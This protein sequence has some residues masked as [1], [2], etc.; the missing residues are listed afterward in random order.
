[1][2]SDYWFWIAFEDL[3]VS[4][5]F[6]LSFPQKVERCLQKRYS[7]FK[8][9]LFKNSIPWLSC[10]RLRHLLVMQTLIQNEWVIR[11]SRTKLWR[12]LTKTFPNEIRIYERI[13]TKSAKIIRFFPDWMM[14]STFQNTWFLQSLK[15]SEGILN[16][17]IL[18]FH[19]LSERI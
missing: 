7:C 3:K 8:G 12:N 6:C 4:H 5:S 1:M 19:E 17:L 14:F 16:L 11:N 9:N 15:T 2:F 13:Q 18:E 10:A